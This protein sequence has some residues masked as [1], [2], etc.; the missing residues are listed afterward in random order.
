MTKVSEQHAISKQEDA[1]RDSQRL[2]S[3]LRRTK[4]LCDTVGCHRRLPL[5][6]AHFQLTEQTALAEDERS[7]SQIK[8]AGHEITG[9][10]VNGIWPGCSAAAGFAFGPVLV[11]QIA[12]LSFPQR[13]S[14]AYG[15]SS[16]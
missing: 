8:A 16:I 10:E 9:C 3:E 5:P 11:L 15:V 13:P 12:G 1:Q 14:R 2:K 6:D 7:G 4:E